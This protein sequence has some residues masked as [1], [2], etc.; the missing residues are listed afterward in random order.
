MPDAGG[1]SVSLPPSK[2]NKF[3]DMSTLVAVVESGSFSEAARRLGTTKSIVSHRVQ[4]LEKRLGCALLTRGR[5]LQLTEPGRNSFERS[6]LLLQ[7][8]ERMEDEG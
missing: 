2:M 1:L 5:P 4:Q 3:S 7:E 6:R 8:L